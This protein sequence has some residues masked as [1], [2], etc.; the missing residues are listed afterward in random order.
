VSGVRDV[1]PG[2]AKSD[3]L[4]PT[5]GRKTSI[6]IAARLIG[7]RELADLIEK[8]AKQSLAQL[9]AEVKTA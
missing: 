6:R 4:S 9:A 5:T 7:I 1:Q 2:V 8:H 3:T